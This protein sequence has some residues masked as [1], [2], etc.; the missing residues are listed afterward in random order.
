MQQHFLS[1]VVRF[2]DVQPSINVVQIFQ[3][4]RSL[5]TGFSR[6]TRLFQQNQ[7]AGQW[8]GRAKLVAQSNG[9]TAIVIG[10]RVNEV[11]R[12]SGENAVEETEKKKASKDDYR[13]HS[14]PFESS[15]PTNEGDEKSGFFL[16]LDSSLLLTDP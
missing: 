2:Q 14:N 15:K 13:R 10:R 1:H 12:E 4:G 16:S 8:S 3:I 6:W 9:T 7:S 5:A 11:A